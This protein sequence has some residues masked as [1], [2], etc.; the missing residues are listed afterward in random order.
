MNV[1]KEL[2][3]ILADEQKI[4]RH[5]GAQFFQYDE[6]KSGL[7]RVGN[8]LYLADNAGEIVFDRVLLEVIRQQ[9]PDIEIRFVVKEKPAINDALVKDA[10]DC[11]IQTVAEVISS[12]S[13]APG[14]L[15]PYCSK[16]FRKRFQEADMVI[17]KGQ[18]NFETL[19]DV[20]RPIYFLL[21]AKCPVIAEDIGCRVGDVI[22]L[23]HNEIA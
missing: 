14:T 6:F 17:S 20:K 16:S 10:T 15:L 2:E 9:Y 1:N 19:S 12:G 23:N 7:K 22:L 4:I 5:E 18:G 21:L 8:I 13:D 11:G 3:K